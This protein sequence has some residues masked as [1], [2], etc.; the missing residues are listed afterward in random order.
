MKTKSVLILLLL[1]N[2]CGSALAEGVYCPQNA[3]YIDIGMSAE[4]VLA[5]CGEPLSRQ[6]PNTAATQQVPVT[7]LMFSNLNTGN[8]TYQ[9]LNS[10]FSIWG[11]SN[12]QTGTNLE[13]D[14]INNKVSAVNINGTNTNAASLCGPNIKIGSP[15][16][17]VY[18]ACGTPA[19]INNTFINQPIPSNSRPEIWIYQLSQYQTPISLT[20]VDGKLQSIQ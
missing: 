19:Q 1:L 13:I 17:S 12:G 18:A 4:Q 11:L 5:A 2:A 6:Q 7:Q 10:Q 8:W 15:A 16:S 3:G 20:F 14:L 9:G